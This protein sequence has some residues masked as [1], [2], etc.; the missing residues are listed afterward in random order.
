MIELKQCINKLQKKA[1]SI[2]GNWQGKEEKEKEGVFSDIS[3]HSIHLSSL[4]TKYKTYI[5]TGG[6][7]ILNIS[8]VS[9]LKPDRGTCTHTLCPLLVRKIN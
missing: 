1:D 3:C 8:Q 6:H 9:K 7:N 2:T 4:Y 5:Q